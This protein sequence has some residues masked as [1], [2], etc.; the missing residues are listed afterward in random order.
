MHDHLHV[1]QAFEDA[2]GSVYVRVLNMAGLY[3]QM[4]HISFMSPPY[5]SMSKY[6]SVSLNIP[7]NAFTWL[8]IA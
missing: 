4:L 2:L 8:N 3:M 7:Q 5:A 6:G 1:P